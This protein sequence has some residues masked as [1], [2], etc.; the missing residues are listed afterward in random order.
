MRRSSR[1]LVFGLC[2]LLLG[3][4]NWGMGTAKMN[5]YKR[6]RAYAVQIGGAG[7]RERF[8]GTQSILQ[9]RGTAHELYEDARGKYRYYRVVHHGGRVLAIVGPV[10]VAGAV[11]R[12]TTVPDPG[13]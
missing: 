4:G 6:Q 8:A 12:R 9:E 7:V 1:V 10:L 13:Y 11:I 3:L 5:H 2:F